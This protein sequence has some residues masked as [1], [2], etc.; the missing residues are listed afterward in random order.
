MNNVHVGNYG[1]VDIDVES[2]GIKI[3]GLIGRNLEELFSKEWP[4]C[5]WMIF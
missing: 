4:A 1:V 3:K 2:D 5:H